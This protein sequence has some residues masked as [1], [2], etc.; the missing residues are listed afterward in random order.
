MLSSIA[1]PTDLSPEGTAAFEHALGL[2]LF[3]R[4]RFEVLHVVGPDEKSRWGAYPR[5]RE[6][7]QRWGLL[8]AGAPV[9]A[10]EN[11]TG[12]KVR[13]V[14]IYHRDPIDG[15]SRYLRDHRSELIVMASH[16]R[17][18]LGRWLNHSV[19]TGLA[20]MSHVPTLILG[21]GSRPFVDSATGRVDIDRVLVPVDHQPDA[22]GAL[23]LLN[24]LAEGRG[25]TLDFVH[26]G[27]NPPDLRSEGGEPV[28]V[29]VLEGPVV[30]TLLAEAQG[31]SLV[32]MPM[33]GPQGLADALRG[34]TTERLVRE[35]TCPV[36]AIP[37]AS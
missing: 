6:V 9:E 10:V 36:L 32:A 30:G 4:S 26:V 25:I 24:S 23:R 2:A 29:R 37:V 28:P 3:N 33:A 17:T 20:Q 8:E 21:P 15:L 7:L 19:S 18:G 11:G 35:V 5:V 34:S 31:A 27:S 1:H 14:E 16:G 13:K 12:I 22:Q